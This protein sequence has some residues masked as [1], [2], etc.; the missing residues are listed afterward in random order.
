[1]VYL[2]FT[3]VF[4]LNELSYNNTYNLSLFIFLQSGPSWSWL[5]CSW[6]YN[7]LC[8][9]CLSPLML[10]VEIPRRQVVLDTTLCDK[11][12]SGF[13]KVLPFLP[14]ISWL[15][16]YSWNIVESGIKHH[17]PNPISPIKW[18]LHST[19]CTWYNIM[20]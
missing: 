18:F 2:I 11:L 20:W 7:Y 6:I 10:W 13:L 16:W 19:R 12:V 4:K 15:P 14:P 5:Y 3:I 1:M 8:N 17:N 9:E